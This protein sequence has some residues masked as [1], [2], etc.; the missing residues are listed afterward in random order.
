MTADPDRD[1]AAASTSEEWSAKAIDVVDTVVDVVHDKVVRPAL[2]AGRAVV[3]GVLIAFVATVVLILLAVGLVRLLDVYAF[4]GRVWASD[5]LFGTIFC[6]GGFFL[7]SLRTK[8]RA[9][10]S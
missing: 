9:S 5:A 7:W 2:I 8:R 1:A 6:G 4:G 10:D 3:F